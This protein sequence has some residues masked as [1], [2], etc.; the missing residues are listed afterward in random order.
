[1]VLREVFVQGCPRQ[2]VGLDQEVERP[3]QEEGGSQG[4]IEGS[5]C[6]ATEAAEGQ[7][8]CEEESTSQLGEP[9]VVEAV[10]VEDL[11]DLGQDA[12]DAVVAVADDDL[13]HAEELEADDRTRRGEN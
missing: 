6:T 9:L 13:A 2:L 1:M 12:G 8:P 10:G 4:S 11:R 7:R 3:H 5:Q